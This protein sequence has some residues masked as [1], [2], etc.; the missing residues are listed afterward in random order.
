MTSEQTS[1]QTSEAQGAFSKI[2]LGYAV[3]TK[4]SD[5]KEGKHGGEARVS[6]HFVAVGLD[7]ENRIV[8]LSVDAVD[9]T[10]Q[11]TEDGH[12]PEDAAAAEVKS[13]YDLGADYAMKEA[14]PIK[15][16]WNEQADAFVAYAKGKTI[17]ELEKGIQDQD[18]DLV[19]GATIKLDS[20]MAALKMA[21]E[22]TKDA[23]GEKVR[24][25]LEMSGSSIKDRTDDK[26]GKIQYTFT[27]TAVASDAQGQITACI[28]DAIQPNVVVGKDGALG[29]STESVRGKKALGDE[30]GMKKASPI[31]KEWFEQ[32]EAIENYVVGKNADAVQGIKTE[33]KDDHHQHSIAEPDLV[34]SATIDI[35]N[36]QKVIVEALGK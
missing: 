35:G 29:E 9:T 7:A 30:Y 15:K 32:A 34:S 22:Q 21:Q 16:E 23:T 31:K 3:S 6:G 25:G 1:T 24:L 26:D 36:I 12:V 4:T 5:P 18:A 17:E 11:L 13:K 8:D 27:I 33:K 28:L 20:M 14:S 2:G 10:V 19:S